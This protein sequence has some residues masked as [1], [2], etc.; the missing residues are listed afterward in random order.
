MKGTEPLSWALRAAP[1]AGW[2]GKA[3]MTAGWWDWGWG[4][5]QGMEPEK[6]SLLWPSAA[7]ERRRGCQATWS[8]FGERVKGRAGPDAAGVVPTIEEWGTQ[9]EPQEQG[10]E[11]PL[12]VSGVMAHTA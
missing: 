10:E 7:P 3:L 4:M 11:T 8:H 6:V 9:A 5:V 2:L 1:V 12:P